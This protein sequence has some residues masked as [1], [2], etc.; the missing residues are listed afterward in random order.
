M[1]AP[2]QDSWCR[3]KCPYLQS[4]MLQ[5]YDRADHSFVTTLGQFW[6]I[7]QHPASEI[8]KRQVHYLAFQKLH[9]KPPPPAHESLNHRPLACINAAPSLIWKHCPDVI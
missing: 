1:A 5:R 7:T 4:P 2:A 6:I 8:D 3:Y 9:K